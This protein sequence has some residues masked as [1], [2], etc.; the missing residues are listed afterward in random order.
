M[1]WMGVSGA[2]MHPAHSGH[3]KVLYLCFVFLLY[4]DEIFYKDEAFTSII[5]TYDAGA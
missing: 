4:N 5:K 2:L 3:C 1:C